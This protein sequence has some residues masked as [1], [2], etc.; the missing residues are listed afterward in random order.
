[1]YNSSLLE[2]GVLDDRSIDSL[3]FLSRI[4][5]VK[6]KDLGNLRLAVL[7]QMVLI[8]RFLRVG[9]YIRV[10]KHVAQLPFSHDS[11]SFLPLEFLLALIDDIIFR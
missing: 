11:V 5:I 7:A 2:T 1:M 3:I 10:E 4:H 9:L 8:V 6:L